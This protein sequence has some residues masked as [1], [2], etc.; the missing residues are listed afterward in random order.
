MCKYTGDGVIDVVSYV[1]QLDALWSTFASMMKTRFTG[2]HDSELL[3]QMTP[4]FE[5]GFTHP[6]K[7]IKNQTISLWN[8]TFG[9]GAPLKYPDTL[10]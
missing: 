9:Q 8:T 6:R 7:L 4:L 5:V 2:T 10:K 1:R 3:L